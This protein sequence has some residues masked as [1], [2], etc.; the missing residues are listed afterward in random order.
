MQKQLVRL[1][2]IAGALALPLLAQ[3]AASA[4]PA[5]HWQQPQQPSAGY[6]SDRDRDVRYDRN[7]DDD[8]N[9]RRD[10]NRDDHRDRDDH[11]ARDDGRR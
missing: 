7:R 1:A 5:D 11:P 6:H 4:S 8:R 9:D 3:T 2:A 10:W